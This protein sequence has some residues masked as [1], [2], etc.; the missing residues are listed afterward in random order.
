MSVTLQIA[1]GKKAVLA[2]EDPPWVKAAVLTT[3]LLFLGLVLVR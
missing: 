1:S 3:V 2:T